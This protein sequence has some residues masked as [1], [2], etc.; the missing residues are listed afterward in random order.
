V[1]FRFYH[2]SNAFRLVPEVGVS[3]AFPAR[4][5]PAF[6]LLI[7]SAGVTL[8]ST[9][10]KKQPPRD[11]ASYKITFSATLSY[12]KFTAEFCGFLV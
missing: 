4:C 10:E 8:N 11:A 3:R 9:H 12:Y 5:R 1:E 6:Q 7:Q 2:T